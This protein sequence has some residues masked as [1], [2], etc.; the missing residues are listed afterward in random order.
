MPP[1]VTPRVPSIVRDVGRRVV[2]PVGG[3]RGGPLG[4]DPPDET[5]FREAKQEE[6]YNVTN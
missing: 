4:G 5:G 6:T 3:E 2:A 1:M